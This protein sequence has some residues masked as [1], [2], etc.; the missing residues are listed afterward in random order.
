M[1][2]QRDASVDGE[3]EE[4]KEEARLVIP[5]TELLDLMEVALKKQVKLNHLR[6][7]LTLFISRK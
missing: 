6:K 1:K 3:A 4:I 7:S 2:H 5:K